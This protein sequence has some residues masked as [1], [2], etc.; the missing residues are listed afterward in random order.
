MTRREEICIPFE[1][2]DIDAILEAPAGDP[3]GTAFL[4]AHGSG[5]G[6]NSEFMQEIAAGLVARGHL[7]MR[8]DYPY[9]AAGKKAPDRMPKLGA[10]ARVA[11]PGN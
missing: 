1:D 9:M 5:A 6:M 10:K 8:F 4:L 11:A 2:E 7:V 3:A